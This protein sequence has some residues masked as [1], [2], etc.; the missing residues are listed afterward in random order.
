LK[1]EEKVYGL[2]IDGEFGGDEAIIYFFIDCNSLISELFV[3]SNDFLND[4]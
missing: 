4:F 1:E 2:F 3:F